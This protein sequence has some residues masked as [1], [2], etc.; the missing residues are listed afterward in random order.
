MAVESTLSKHPNLLPN[1]HTWYPVAILATFVLFTEVTSL[2][3]KM[4]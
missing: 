4:L 2:P 1:S 3:V